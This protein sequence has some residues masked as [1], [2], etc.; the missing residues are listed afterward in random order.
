MRSAYISVWFMLNGASLSCAPACGSSAFPATGISGAYAFEV[1]GAVGSVEG[2]TA[3]FTVS[4]S[5]LRCVPGPPPSHAVLVGH[6]VAPGPVQKG[7]YRIDR[8][9]VPSESQTMAFVVN[10]PSGIAP[11]EPHIAVGGE[12][13]ILEI[14]ESAMRVRVSMTF[15]DGKRLAGS[16]SVSLCGSVDGSPKAVPDSPHKGP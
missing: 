6:V 2:N 10:R 14:T 7:S 5:E 15:D 12:I 8:H 3:T 16:L 4:E 9:D 13:E 1:K 11:F